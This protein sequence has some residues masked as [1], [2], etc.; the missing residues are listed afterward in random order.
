M[1]APLETTA[2]VWTAV[3]TTLVLM[4]ITAVVTWPRVRDEH[5]GYRAAFRRAEQRWTFDVTAAGDGVLV[6]RMDDA[7][8]DVRVSTS[9]PR[10]STLLIMLGRGRGDA[11]PLTVRG[12][13]S[14]DRVEPGETVPIQLSHRADTR[15]E[16]EWTQPNGEAAWS[17]HRIQRRP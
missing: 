13:P 9:S 12:R 10:R 3:V 16:V 5:R 7:V 2:D 8:R 6:N 14:V 4:A 17:C 11:V 1:G 15:L